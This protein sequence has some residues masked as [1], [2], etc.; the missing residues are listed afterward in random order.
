MTIDSVPG[1]SST[2]VSLDISGSISGTI[3]TVDVYGGGADEDWYQVFL[4]EGTTYQF[5]LSSFFI[6]GI[7]ALYDADN[8]L[9]AYADNGLN[10]G[11]PESLYY[12]PTTGGTYYITVSGYGGTTGSFQLEAMGNA[13]QTGDF[14]VG[15]AST[16]ASVSVSGTVWGHID[17]AD[18]VGGSDS[19]WY[20]VRLVAGATYRVDLSGDSN[21]DGILNLYDTD[22][23]S[24]L[25]DADASYQGGSEYF[26]YSPSTTGD[27]YIAVDGWGSTIG[28]FW[29]SVSQMSEESPSIDTVGQTPGTSV[30]VAVSSNAPGHVAGTINDGLDADWYAVNLAADMQCQFDLGSSSLDGVLQLYD[31]LGN[32]LS[33]IDNNW[34]VGPENL[35]CAPATNGTYY[36]EV[37][38]YGGSTGDFLL[39]I[40]SSVAVSNVDA[41]GDTCHT[42]ASGMLDIE[43]GAI[44]GFVDSGLDEDVYSVALAANTTYLL[45]LS[46]TSLDGTL[47]LYGTTGEWLDSADYGGTGG[48]E[49]LYF[50]P[51]ASGNYCISVGGWS[52]STG[53]YD[54]TASAL[55][56]AGGEVPGD[57]TSTE[58]LWV[59]GFIDNQIDSGIDE[60]WFSI[61]LNQGS[62]YNFDLYSNDGVLDGI[63]Q[64]F[65]ANGLPVY[66]QYGN[67][68][69]DNGWYAG[70]AESL[71]FTAPTT[72]DYFIQ[73]SGFGGT[74]GSYSLYAAEAWDGY[75]TVTSYDDIKWEVIDWWSWDDAT[76][77]AYSDLVAW[78][79]VG[80]EEIA[81]YS[82]LEWNYVDWAEFDNTTYNLLEYEQIDWDEL[83]VD[84]WYDIDWNYIDAISLS[85]DQLQYEYEYDPTVNYDLLTGWDIDST[86][87]DAVGNIGNDKVEGGVANDTALLGMGLD[88]FIGGLGDD[89]A[90]GGGGA[91]YL[92]G[93]DGNDILNGGAGHDAMEGGSG[94]DTY[95]VD[96]LNDSAIETGSVSS[97]LSFRLALS[98]GSNIDKVIASISYTLGSSLEN[99]D[100]AS[101]GGNLTGTG[102]ALANALAGNEGNNTLTGGAG[103]DSL[104]G[105]VGIDIAAYS[106]SRAGFTLA[107]SGTGFIVTDSAGTEGVDTATNIER[108]VFADS[109]IAVDVIDGNA[110]T[111]A[112]I[113]G[114]VFGRDSVSNT[115]FVGIGLSYLD[116]GMSYVDLMSLALNAAGVT[117]N[118]A[119]VGL[120]WTNLFGSAPASA[121]AAPY[122]AMLESGSLSAGA[123]GVLAADTSL[124]TANI[125]LTG[126]NGLAQTGIVYS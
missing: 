55:A 11:D 3:D 88:Y 25:A 118:T 66:D 42:A 23:T 72:G 19:D 96:S 120:L 61:R 77:A 22:G 54:L 53:S 81:D 78:S 97:A 80:W 67:G 36:I 74:T 121:E 111:T 29:L 15:A 73:V 123:L 39:D 103:N 62:K 85:W 92:A 37:S 20:N 122:V 104:D 98:L 68:Y 21:L 90:D 41:V 51:F 46:S 93:G 43:G 44:R 18:S 84:D 107:Q 28:D 6:D 112:K 16:S 87:A 7:L 114:A 12:T 10:V 32:Q 45:G 109:R 2:T 124:N 63:L 5:D 126:V 52:S 102:N 82:A 79:A 106:G 17:T 99:L 50:T 83:L 8:V 117:T 101:G 58:N 100:L 110:G 71:H 27:Y 108:L 105:G 47:T 13:S 115:A 24:T 86:I 40:Y 113:L 89:Y 64:I 48:E 125:N 75:L 119:I 35:V 76:W 95:Y 1:G 49:N 65:D 33:Y 94:D 69:A 9:Q 57:T 60:D 14:V 70:D 4:A 56:I 26:Y 31:F 59:P 34:G 38:G 91:D 30:S 116:G